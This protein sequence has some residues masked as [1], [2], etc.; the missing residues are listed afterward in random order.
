MDK[1]GYD[2]PVIVPASFQ[3]EGSLPIAL[4]VGSEP[5]INVKKLYEW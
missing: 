2:S 5:K 4:I 3:L 1:R